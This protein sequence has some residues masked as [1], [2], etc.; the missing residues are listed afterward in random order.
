MNQQG[1][2]HSE[3]LS[4]SPLKTTNMMEMIEIDNDFQHG[5]QEMD[6]STTFSGWIGIASNMNKCTVKHTRW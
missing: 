1:K 5:L 3:M 6:L 2:D 4:Q